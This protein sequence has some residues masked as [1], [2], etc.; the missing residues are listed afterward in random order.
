MQIY[1]C[2]CGNKYPEH[3][4][5]GGT[6]V[7]CGRLVGTEA[8]EEARQKAK[9]YKRLKEEAD[10]QALA[11]QE[12]YQQHLKDQEEHNGDDYKNNGSPLWLQHKLNNLGTELEQM[13]KNNEEI[14]DKLSRAGKDDPELN[15]IEMWTKYNYNSSPVGEVEAPRYTNAVRQA[16]RWK[17]LFGFLIALAIIIPVYLKSFITL[18][19]FSIMVGMFMYWQRDKLKPLRRYNKRLQEIG[20]W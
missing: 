1:E 8:N 2:D 5:N 11:D 7:N 20:E 18:L 17:N 19:N 6:C 9:E 10:R 12:Y 3:Q 15:G 13:R 4:W 16:Q 14:L